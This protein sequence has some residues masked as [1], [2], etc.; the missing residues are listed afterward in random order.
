MT[1]APYTQKDLAAPAPAATT[2]RRR[3]GW[4]VAAC[5]WLFAAAVVALWALVR[6]QS[7]RWWPATALLFGPR[8]V[9]A[10]PVV[11]LAPAALFLA[12]RSLWVQAAAV[13]WVV[14]TFMNLCLPW[15]AVLDESPTGPTLRVLSLNTHRNFL[16]APAL[17][18]YIDQVE[19]DVVALQDWKDHTL[20]EVFPSRGWHLHV[21]NKELCLASRHPI[22]DARPVLTGPALTR[23]GTCLHYR[24]DTPAGTV[25]FCN[26]HLA[27]PRRGLT[28][29]MEKWW[30][31][32]AALQANSDMRREQ[33]VYIVS[34]LREVDG[35]LLLA[36]DFNTPEDSTLYDEYWSRYANAFSRKGLGW[37][38]TFR[39]NRA[40]VRIDHQ[41]AGP[42]WRCVRCWVGPDVGSQHRPLVADWEWT[43]L[44]RY[45]DD[46]PA[47]SPD[48]EPQP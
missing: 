18:A 4:A 35:P 36:G 38:F 34:G 5:S 12:P 23:R 3:A 17:R 37:G 29:V 43:G 31:G 21:D 8:W 26:L 47:A 13:L 24:L 32:G 11:G 9:W 27:T 40:A 30:D 22:R 15:R 46:G 25:H 33:A 48:K 16:N 14:G 2:L 28:A 45:D 39:T 6:W 20:P 7:E 1:A 44:V 42:D 19:P 41:L 10:L